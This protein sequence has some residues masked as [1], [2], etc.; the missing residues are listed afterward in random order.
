LSAFDKMVSEV[1]TQTM[2]N[3]QKCSQFEIDIEKLAQNMKFQVDSIQSLKGKVRGQDQGEGIGTSQIQAL[4]DQLEIKWDDKLLNLLNQE[5]KG[6]MGRQE[7]ELK[8]QQIMVMRMREELDDFQKK[9]EKQVQ[10]WDLNVKKIVNENLKNQFEM[11]NE[12]KQNLNIM[13]K[14]QEEIKANNVGEGALNGPSQNLIYEL[15]REVKIS[16]ERM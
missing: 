1:I 10:E 3:N 9:N 13:L 11:E 15:E 8:E 12:L 16:R 5:R 14:K 2:Q 6:I 7:Q 4:M